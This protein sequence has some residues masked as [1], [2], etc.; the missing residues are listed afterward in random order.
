M[1]GVVQDYTVAYP[2]DFEVKLSGANQGEICASFSAYVSSY[3]RGLGS[4]AREESI[5]SRDDDHHQFVLNIS[6]LLIRFIYTHIERARRRSLS[7]ILLAASQA[8]TGEDL[9]VRILDYLQN[10][11][12]DARLEVVVASPVGGLDALEPLLDDLISPNDAM[13]LRGSVARLLGSYPDN[14]G[15]LLLRGLSEVLSQDGSLETGLQNLQAGI[16]FALSEYRGPESDD[17]VAP[18]IGKIV[19]SALKKEGAAQSLIIAALE[20]S[21]LSRNIV[22]QLLSDCPP[23]VV[24]LP[25][26]WLSSELNKRSIVMLLLR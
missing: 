7:E 2:T 16:G 3:Q 17:L 11:E 15:L 12:F 14:P 13:A 26:A 23:E 20:V 1:I 5:L 10:S 8:T 4:K 22:R 19:T 18:A 6:K 25:A 21:S 24:W 9:R